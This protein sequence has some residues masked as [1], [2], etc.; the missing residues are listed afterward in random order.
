MTNEQLLEQIQAL[1]E[2]ISI[3]KQTIEALQAQPPKIEYRYTYNWP[4]YNPY[5]FQGAQ[6]GAGV[7]VSNGTGYVQ[8]FTNQNQCFTSKLLP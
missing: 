2:L 6:G 7:T 8:G 5:Q 4:Y 1:K 3:Q